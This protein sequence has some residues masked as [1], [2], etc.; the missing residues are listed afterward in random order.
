MKDKI[1]R[2][3]N[4]DENINQKL[5]ME[6]NSL[7]SENQNLKKEIE[8]INNTLKS[9]TQAVIKIKNRQRKQDI[10]LATSKTIKEIR[11]NISK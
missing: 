5:Q 7:R 10:V 6:I 2:Y 3:F 11:E 4:V 9:M 1:K 8:D